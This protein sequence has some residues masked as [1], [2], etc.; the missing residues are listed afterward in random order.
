MTTSPGRTRV[1]DRAAG[2]PLTA[3]L[4][5]LTAAASRARDSDGSLAAR[6][7]SRRARPAVAS[8]SATVTRSD[9]GREA[10]SVGADGD[11]ADADAVAT[12]RRDGR[13]GAH[14]AAAGQ[15]GRHAGGERGG[16]L[17]HASGKKKQSGRA[18]PHFSLPFPSYTMAKP[19]KKKAPKKPA[20]AGGAPPGPS[21]PSVRVRATTRAG[22]RALAKREPQLVE[23]VKPTLLVCGQKVS[24]TLKVSGGEETGAGERRG[25]ETQMGRRRLA[26]R[27]TKLTHATTPTLPIF[28]P[29]NVLADIHKLKPVRADVEGE[30]GGRKRGEESH[31]RRSHPHHHHPHHTTERVRQADPQKRGPP[32]HGCGRRNVP[33]GSRPPRRLWPVCPCDSHQETPP[34]PHPGPL[35]RRPPAGCCRDDTGRRHHGGGG[36]GSG[37]RRAR[38]GGAQ[39]PALFRG[40]A[41]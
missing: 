24:Q 33:G 17:Q 38:G 1:A 10:E 2:A 28:H 37:R 30:V 40:G 6:K 13:G 23:E 34:R 31:A 32:P 12:R 25:E 16:R 21:R 4:P 41:V 20:T 22:K 5:L 26:K 8:T 9:A 11:A 3:T 14:A 35:L 15:E 27:R 36:G 39:T 19:A 7:A 29:Q 18:L